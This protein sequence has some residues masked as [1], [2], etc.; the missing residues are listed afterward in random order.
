MNSIVAAWRRFRIGRKCF[1]MG[2]RCRFGGRNIQIEGHVELGDFCHLREHAILRA[3]GTGQIILGNQVGLGNY[4]IIEA[5]Q[6]VEIGARTGVLEFAV[7]RDTTHLVRGTDAPWR[8]TP[9]I[10]EPVAIGPDCWIGS[11][12]Y[13][14]PGVTIGE[15]AVVGA[16][17]FVDKDIGP[18]EVWVGVPARFLY[19]RTADVPAAKQAEAARLIAEQGIAK[20]RYRE[21]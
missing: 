8:L 14:S 17:S 19:H 1:R 10:V 4:C 9:H 15:G 20:D 7:I 6:R 16:K 21:Q 18:F 11:G 13:I 3:A 2:K 12:A 5:S